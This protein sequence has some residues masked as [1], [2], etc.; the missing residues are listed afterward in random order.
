MPDT[1]NF[2]G[3]KYPTSKLVGVVEFIASG[4]EWTCPNDECDTFHQT[5]ETKS[6]VKC[7]ECGRMYQ[8]D[9]AYHAYG[10]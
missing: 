9:G 2:L 6:I 1:F 10:S 3:K 7:T 4:Y 8:V 5:I